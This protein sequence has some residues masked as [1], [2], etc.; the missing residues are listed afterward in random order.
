[1]EP[2]QFLTEL[3]KKNWVILEIIRK[4]GPVTKTDIS[5]LTG[6]NIVTVSNYVN[7]YLDQGLVRGRGLDS[8]TGGRKPE[9]VE[10]NS[11]FAFAVGLD[12]GPLNVPAADMTAILT[13]LSG[14]VIVKL[15]RSRPKEDIDRLLDKS[16]G[17]ISEL[18]K[19]SAVGREKIKGAGISI[20][21]V[22]LSSYPAI[23]SRIEQEFGM[24]VFI[25][26]DANLSAFG[27]KMIGL[28]P[29]V[30]N[31]VYLHSETSCG[32]IINGEIYRGTS[33]STGELAFREQ[34]SNGNG[35][36]KARRGPWLQTGE[37]GLRTL[38]YAKH[39]LKQGVESEINQIAGE[40]LEQ[41]TFQTI[42]QAAKNGD[43]LAME[44]VEDAGV[45]LGMRVACLVNIF[46]PEMVIIGGGLIGTGS[47][48]LD[49]IR[50]TVK[51]YAFE[52]TASAA[53][54]LPAQL[55]EDSAVAGA[56]GLVIR[57]VFLQA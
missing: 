50:K 42:T 1:M 57:E 3:E 10:L 25:D 17:L 15:K 43:K 24:P 8:S 46:N 49:P 55:G 18:I 28:T 14:R 35:F 36:I 4:N 48:L 41:L 9:L 45:N 31:I 23:K 54:I 13:N 11:D 19:N 32:I 51:K 53:K 27:E 26:N 33:G 47:L 21:A 5:Q 56:A 39:I 37:S 29:E 34:L 16:T 38:T 12:L 40:N 2:K 30:K 6:I 52:E 7:K 20:P 22:A 44:L